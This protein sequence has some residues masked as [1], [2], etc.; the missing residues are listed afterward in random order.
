MSAQCV[1]LPSSPGGQGPQ[2]YPGYSY[3]SMQSTPLKQGLGLQRDRCS[4]KPEKRRAGQGVRRGGPLP[5][6]VGVEPRQHSPQTWHS[7]MVLRIKDI[8]F[9]WEAA[10]HGASGGCSVLAGTL[11]LGKPNLGRAITAPLPH[12]VP[13]VFPQLSQDPVEEGQL[14]DQRLG[15]LTC[16]EQKGQGQ[17]QDRGSLPGPWA[18]DCSAPPHRTRRTRQPTALILPPWSTQDLFPCST[19]HAL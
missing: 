4:W 1:P 13:N 3:V 8:S 19:S 6:E 18:G 15:L 12:L 11:L 5:P 17:P 9:T 10:E 7:M 14:C 16:Q 2:R